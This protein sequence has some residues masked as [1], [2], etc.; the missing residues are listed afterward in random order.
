RRYSVTGPPAFAGGWR[1]LRTP[2]AIVLPSGDNAPNSILSSNLGPVPAVR[3]LPSPGAL[4][5]PAGPAFGFPVGF[6]ALQHFAS[7][8]AALRRFL[9]SRL[10]VPDGHDVAPARSGTSRRR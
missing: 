3:D 5:P 7:P 1:Y 4:S 2:N 8:Q 9:L 10:D 6:G